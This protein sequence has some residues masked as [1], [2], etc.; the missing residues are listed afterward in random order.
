MGALKTFPVSTI[1]DGR[2]VVVAGNGEAASAKLRLLAKTSAEVHVFADSP[3]PTL[4]RTA[5]SAGYPV[6]TRL[7][8]ADDFRGAA[9]AFIATEIE[10]VD[11]ELGAMAR[12]AGV[13]VNV[14]DR[15]ELCDVLTPAF[16][17][18]APVTIAISTEGA[19][20]VLAGIL[21]ARIE[22]IL[23]PGTGLLAGL[24]G[25]LRGRVADL[26][27]PGARRL[28]FWRSYFTDEGIAAA[29]TRGSADVRR[30]AVRLMEAARSGDARTGFVWLVGAGPGAADLLTLRARRVLAEA[31][32][33]VYDALVDNDVL[34]VVRRDAR[35][36]DVGKRKGRAPVGQDRINDI[37]IEEAAAGHTVVRLKSGDPMIYGRAGEEIAALRRAGIEHAVVPGI[38]AALGAAAET[39]TPLTHREHASALVFATG[40]AAPGENDIDWA[41]IARA[42]ATVTLYMAKSVADETARS[43][44]ENGLS[45]DTPV[46]AVE[47]A[48]RPVQ[49]RFYGR[50]ADLPHLAGRGDVGG[51]VVIF[52]GRAVAEG[53]WGGA[54]AFADAGILAA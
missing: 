14:V 42:D 27:P 44:I 34:D 43:L 6:H 37:L 52:I 29:A 39:A 11:R 53:D 36:I 5:E 38:T 1:V 17:D 2:R 22:E 40:H 33:V 32:V 8:G 26:L 12:A 24:A 21:R 20:P 46:G 45:P 4:A 41:D 9:L 18:R 13:T 35:R 28:A 15:P 7:P 23:T 25:E 54:E 16:V 48:C 30:R 10:S 49:R 50:L 47:N 19:A 51:P 3:E 31:D